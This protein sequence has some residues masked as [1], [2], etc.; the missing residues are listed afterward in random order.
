MVGYLLAVYV[1]SLKHLGLT[2]EVGE[3]F[4]S[5]SRRGQNIGTQLLN[6]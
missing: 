1:F 3:L 2:A 5:P 6:L 4:V